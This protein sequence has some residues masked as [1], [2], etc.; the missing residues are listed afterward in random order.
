VVEA[1]TS[2][3]NRLRARADRTLEVCRVLFKSDEDLTS[4]VIDPDQLYPDIDRSNN[5][6]PPDQ[7][8]QSGFA[9]QL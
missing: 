2:G 5:T 6:W 7:I 4:V 3:G 8:P 9:G 1:I